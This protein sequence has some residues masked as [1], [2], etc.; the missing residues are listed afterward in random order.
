MPSLFTELRRR[1]VFKV[2]A[3]Y[4]I[5]AWLLVQV[6][7][8]VLPA[9]Q[10]PEWTISFVTVLLIIGFPITLIMA[11]AFEMT[12]EGIKADADVP[13]DSITPATGQRLNYVILGLVVLAVGFLVVDQYVLGPRASLVT[14][15]ITGVSDEAVRSTPQ[16]VSA[17]PAARV[18]RASIDLGL[19]ERPTGL[20]TD[21]ALS[22]DG[23]RLIY[24]V[25]MEGNRQLFLRELDQLEPQPIAGTEG[26]SKP[27]FSPDGEWVVFRDGT[28]LKRVSV[29]GGPPQ[30]VADNPH[31]G[32]SGFWTFDQ[33]ILFTSTTDL[34]LHR[35]P[36]EGGTS[37]RLMD[38][39]I[40]SVEVQSWPQVLPGEE[41]VLFT[42]SP[43]D[44]ARDGRI[45]LLSLPT[46]EVR[47]LIQRGYNARYAHS[48][49]IVFMRSETLWA[50][51]FDL[52]RLQIIGVQVPIIQGVETRGNRGAA[53]YAF[54]DD[55]LLV[56]LPGTD[57]NLRGGERILVWVDR[58][59]RE[60]ALEM[61]PQY[62]RHPRIA[63][64]GEQLAVTVAEADGTS[65]V[66]THDLG[67]GTLSRRTFTGAAL[68]PVWT[69]NSERL[70]FESNLQGLGL[71]WI[72]ADGTGQPERITTEP[73]DLRPE[74]FSPDG[75]LLVYREGPAPFDL[76]V[77]SMDGERTERPL[78]V[79][80]FTEGRSDISPDGRWIAYASTESGR[81]E[82]YVRR[83]PSL[84]GKWQ[85][86]TDGG[87]EP[88]WGP[89]GQEIYYRRASD[90]SVLA[91]SVE[92]E[93]SFTA[94]KPRVLITGDYL[95]LG[96]PPSYDVSLDGQRFLMIKAVQETSAASAPQQTS[97][98]VVY[99][100]F[101]ELN[102]LAPPSP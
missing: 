73:R 48:G 86:T 83:F 64:D 90:N 81:V 32:T 23:Y 27:F 77:L 36:A 10:M 101:E 55:G 51:P 56:Y 1:N 17:D 93:P 11:W 60:E 80:E 41:A 94:G 45:D 20:R 30:P 82:V 61:E 40:G 99:N 49:H 100:W 71:W 31:N 4:A 21:I 74:A 72:A 57:T 79:T 89:D 70:V 34:S 66:W 43:L 29:H 19:M 76:Y 53:G 87:N 39:E 52:D 58:E 47:T 24:S 91:V 7:D 98:V 16:A 62:Y 33:T 28:E 69:P 59:G 13:S 37:E 95:D 12:P 54:S 96:T 78:I 22:L 68:R 50:A 75:A 44:A 2:G 84:D 8:V 42:V 26:A 25:F 63:P 15:S 35:V 46:G 97:L 5:V 18:L 3:A 38:N 9:L 92:T 65:D 85:I 88:R 6:V 14:G 102:R 67:R